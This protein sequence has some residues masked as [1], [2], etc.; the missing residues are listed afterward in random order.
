MTAGDVPGVLRGPFTIDGHVHFYDCFDLKR[1]LE[2]AWASLDSVGITSPPNRGVGC[3]LLT[4]RP[5]DHWFRRWY[6]SGPHD[7]GPGWSFQPGADGITL[8]ATRDGVTK[9][10][11]ISGRQIATREGLEVLVVGTRQEF[12]TGLTFS[13]ALAAAREAQ[14]VTIVPWGF[15]KWTGARGNLVRA[16]IEAGDHPRVFLGDN[17]GRPRI[18]GTPTLLALG[19]T[20]GYLVLPGSDPLP[21]PSQLRRVGSFGF[22]VSGD[23]RADRAGSDLLELIRALSEQPP[24]F[25]RASTLGSFV[26][27]QTR[28]QLQKRL[29]KGADGQSQ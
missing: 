5:Q 13:G 10:I 9:L 27:T 11:I 4:E 14:G 28:A 22:V 3:L 29:R 20:R 23:L 1:F 18:G 8:L 15:G 16:L 7:R 25:G 12:G 19:R 17:G 6:E 24:V 2:T 26:V 21:F